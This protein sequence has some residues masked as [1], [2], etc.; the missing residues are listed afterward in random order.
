MSIVLNNIKNIIERSKK[1]HD[2]KDTFKSKYPLEKRSLESKRIREKYPD[3]IPVICEKGSIDL[4]D[5]DKIKYLCPEDL[6]L[7]NFMYVLRRRMQLAPEKSIYFFI[8][9]TLIPCSTNLGEVYKE[10]SDQDG[11][12]YIKYCG[13]NTFG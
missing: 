10:H 13:E 8:N 12:L 9:N 1:T 5:L 6:N 4:P 7:M 3:R 11:F 2:L